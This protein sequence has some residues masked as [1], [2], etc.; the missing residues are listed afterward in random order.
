[1]STSFTIAAVSCWAALVLVLVLRAANG[2]RYRPAR[3]GARFFLF[4]LVFVAPAGDE[5][6]AWPQMRKL[7]AGH[8]RFEYGPGMDEQS[9]FGRTVYYVPRAAE[10]TETMFPGVP[11][12]LSF[13]DYVDAHT[14]DVVLRF[15]S[16]LPLGSMFSYPDAKGARHTWLLRECWGANLSRAPD[17]RALKLVVVRAPPLPARKPRPSV[18]QNQSF[19]VPR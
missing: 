8:G 1:M 6:F 16:V 5:M 13:H 9:A 12:R 14:G 11:V 4:A 7:C 3:I 10:R 15:R 18:L 19:R 17:E 2:V